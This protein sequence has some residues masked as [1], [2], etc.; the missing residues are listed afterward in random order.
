[1][2]PQIGASHVTPAGESRVGLGLCVGIIVC[3]LLQILS[4]GYGRD[5]GIYAVVARTILEGGMPYRDAWDFKPPGIFLVYAAARSL[6]GPSQAAVRL[7]EVLSLA[8]MCIAMRRLGIRFWQ[9]GLLGV[10]AA[11][12]AVLGH[13][14]LGFWH[15]GQPES[16][17]GVL[18]VFALWALGPRDLASSASA[19][20]P[21]PSAFSTS[22]RR[23]MAGFLFGL[24][25]LMKPTLVGPAAVAALALAWRRRSPMPLVAILAGGLVPTLS[26]L[27]WFWAKGA[28]PD[29]L[30]TFLVFTPH[31][32]ALAANAGIGGVTL[33][34][35][36]GLL[37]N[38]AGLPLVGL[39]LLLVP[40][41]WSRGTGPAATLAAILAA[42]LAGVAIQGKFFS[43]HYGASVPILA[44]LAAPGLGRAWRYARAWGRLMETLLLVLAAAVTYIHTANAGEVSFW[45][46]SYMRTRALLATHVDQAALDRLESVADVDAGANRDV[47]AYLARETP[48]VRPIFVWGFEPAIY[49]LS[50]RAS[51]TRYIYNVAQRAAW[52]KAVAR[53]RL[54][55][56]LT[57]RP[58]AAIVVEHSDVFFWVTGDEQDSAA[59][60]SGFVE[61]QSLVDRR[62]RLAWCNEKFE[63]YLE[64]PPGPAA[65]ALMPMGSP[66]RWRSLRD[67][68]FQLAASRPAGPEKVPSGPFPAVGRMQR[69]LP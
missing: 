6:F 52:S 53:E 15:T 69:G 37:S 67:K 45:R 13:A 33:R 9:D 63:V 57:A 7:F 61:L 56:D 8:G 11:T 44:L 51:A 54:I 42:Q 32:T 41:L 28:L 34:T 64:R 35:L 59:A 40:G 50:N 16:F 47:S 14:Q 27:A 26:C 17:G 43:Y 55:G 20:M 25:G 39:A 62:Y 48:A 66:L 2:L 19:E 46:Q 22:W 1:M 38:T 12:M 24:A 68:R 60:L 36:A 18:T 58:P 3:S 10:V 30:E 49:D 5:Q 4:F 23:F 65:A 31:Y 29:L 21:P